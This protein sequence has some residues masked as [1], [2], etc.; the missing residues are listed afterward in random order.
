[1]DV[2]AGGGKVEVKV[3]EGE[4]KKNEAKKIMRGKSTGFREKG[5]YVFCEVDLGWFG[6]AVDA[7]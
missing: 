5:K 2:K 7:E 1:M 4:E 6:R 3:E